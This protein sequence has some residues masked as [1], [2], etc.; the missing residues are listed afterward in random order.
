MLCP[1]RRKRLPDEMKFEALSPMKLKPL[2]F[3]AAVGLLTSGAPMT[4][5]AA[6][7]PSQTLKTLEAYQSVAKP[8]NAVLSTPPFET[9]PEAI[10]RSIE[11]A[12][13]NANAGLDRIGTLSSNQVTFDN[14]LRALD[15]VMYQAN[16][17]ANRVYL[18][19]ETSTNET[20]RQVA[21]DQIK[22][23]QDWA[24][25][26]DYREDVYRAIKAYGDTR[27]GLSGERAKLLED[28]LRDYRRAGLALPKD[29]RDDVEKLRKELASKCTDFQSNIT[30]AKAPVRFTRQELE[31]IPE[32]FLGQPGL[33]TGPDEYTLLA[34]VTLQ[35]L[36]VMDNARSEATRKRM[37]IARETIARDKNVALM[38]DIVR[39]RQRI[40]GELGYGSWA[41]YQIEPKMAKNE[42]T[43]RAFLT[44]LSRGLQPKFDAELKEFAAM[45]ARDTGDANAKINVWDARYYSNQLK[46]QKYAI[47]TE[48][49]RAFFPYERTLQG[50][51]DIYSSI[52][53]IRIQ[54]IDAPYR[55]VPELKLY[56]VS[57]AASG[58]PLGLFYLDMFPREG[59]YSHFAHFS[60]IEGKR[61]ADGNYQ[62]PVSALICN[63]PK[64]QPDRPSLLS[65]DEVETLFHEFGHC[66]HSM[67]TRAEFARFSGTSVPGDFVEAPS[68]MLE[69]WIW[70]KKVLDGFAA[71]YRDPSKK[72]PQEII[73]KLK[74][75]KLATVGTHYRRQAALALLDLALH[76]AA[77]S[78]GEIDVVK[79]TNPI[80]AEVYLPEPE[81]TAFI[82]GFGHLAGGYDAGYYGY[83][84]ADAIA[85]DLAT[86]FEK[87]PKGFLDTDAGK[88]LR[89]E[90]YA[91]GG[92]RDANVSIEKFLGRPRSSEPFL[93]S[94]GIGKGR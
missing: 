37:L 41:D 1:R 42:A 67:L 73:E 90:I 24:V 49:L 6:T 25:G 12:I 20:A 43:A 47:D 70:D 76:Q 66:M 3:L 5:M 23:F 62:R 59:K 16:L 46:K 71:D 72:I 17:A 74:E 29:K 89:D 45:K 36:M 57:D 39:L 75:A 52:F 61:L 55:W 81:G 92:S 7:P 85:Q 93:K 8:F 22:A 87:S 64:P 80:L 32:E 84:W 60:L 31:G 94:I 68:Q 18:I 48:Q 4:P 40:A 10:R 86:V 54:E 28:V 51:F 9:T 30:E 33:K 78:N 83:A 88:R 34:N 53:G 14:T 26:L 21:T 50:M 2:K 35:Y 13:T 11:S 77:K 56:A 44:D 91:P 65:H 79:I 38:N 19:K 69:S 27:P 63:F 15:D 58:E 82:A